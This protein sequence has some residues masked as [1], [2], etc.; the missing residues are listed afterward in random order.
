MNPDTLSG[1]GNES[2]VLQIFG[3]CCADSLQNDSKLFAFQSFE[4]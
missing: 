1:D 3:Y 4:P 2:T